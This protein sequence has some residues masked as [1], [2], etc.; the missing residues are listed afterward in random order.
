VMTYQLL[1]DVVERQLTHRLNRNSPLLRLLL[2]TDTREPRREMLDYQ[3]R[4]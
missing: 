1:L 4:E 3:I 2:E